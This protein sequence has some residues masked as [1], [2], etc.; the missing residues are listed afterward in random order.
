MEE[1]EGK[2]EE[3]RER[4]WEMLRRRK[5]RSRWRISKYGLMF[6]ITEVVKEE[7][8]TEEE[9]EYVISE[10]ERAQA[11]VEDDKRQMIACASYRSSKV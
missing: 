5:K 1:E 3:N 4:M 9:V 7:K 2:K 10:A 6:E 8:A 11:K